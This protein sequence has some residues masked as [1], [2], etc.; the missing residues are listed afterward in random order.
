M[1]ITLSRAGEF[2]GYASL[3]HVRDGGGDIILPG[4]FAAS[5]ARRG[6]RGVRMLWQ[7]D[8]ARPLGVWLAMREDERGLFVHGRLALATATGREAAELM[9]MGALDGLSIGFRTIRSRR[10][11]SRRARLVMALDLW[12]ISLVTF[13]ML[14]GARVRS[15]RSSPVTA[16]PLS[17]PSTSTPTTR[18][19]A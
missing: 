11:R 1:T 14:S 8:P 5:L 2:S 13:P 15:I 7:H 4:A 19:P 16:R 9:R 6:P 18:S 17:L 10:D 12:E 3:F